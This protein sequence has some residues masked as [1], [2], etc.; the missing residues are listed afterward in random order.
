MND[1]KEKTRLDKKNKIMIGFYILMAIFEI[2]VAIIEKD[3]T[4]IICA[5]LWGNIALIEYCNAKILKG[6]DAIIEI[7]D[8]HIE[9]QNKLFDELLEHIN[10]KR[11]IIK[12]SDIKIQ[13][14]FKAPNKDKLN[15]RYTYFDK[16]LNFEVPIIVD[17]QNNLIDGYTSYLIAKHYKFSYVEVEEKQCKTKNN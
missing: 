16:Y 9:K 5:L 3:F 1:W 14:K 10:K 2:T 15:R 8:R 6:R 17:S 4:W 11:K 7:K 12:I 13:K